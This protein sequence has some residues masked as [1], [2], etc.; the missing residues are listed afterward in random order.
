[1]E[2]ATM[3]A[4]AAGATAIG[5]FFSSERANRIDRA[6]AAKNRSFQS[7]QAQRQMD[8]QERMRNTSWQSAIADMEAAG[9]NPALAYSQGGAAMA[10]GASGGGSS[11]APSRDSGSSAMQALQVRQAMKL[12][13]EAIR[14][15]G[16]EADAAAAL[17]AREEARNAG[18]GIRKRPDGSFHVDL[19][20]PG[21]VEE[22]QA[23]V[24]QR[25][26]E[27]ARSEA[28]SRIA[29]VGGQV[30]GGFEQMM[31]GFQRI[32]G[33]AGKGAD[34]IGASVEL[35]ERIARMRDDAV[36]AA[37]GM[38]KSAF[39]KVYEALKRRSN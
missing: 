29:G 9:L 13:S 26:A 35:L 4:L 3:T 30:A 16:A 28:M 24:R 14:K 2:P 22:T 11:T 5:G 7:Q 8:F 33:V 32:M 15:T 17:S 38:P 23:G 21:L 37:F 31:P 36:Q 19:T 6:E 34:S 1:M 27:A 10:S 12:Q 20:L 39:M 18:Y 25:V